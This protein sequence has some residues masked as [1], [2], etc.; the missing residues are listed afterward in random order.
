[1]KKAFIHTFGCQM[2]EYDSQRMAHLLTKGGYKLVQGVE[3]ANL[4]LLNSCS[5]RNAPENKIYSFLGR[6][7]NLKKKNKNLIIGVGGC[8]A[9]QEGANILKREPIVDLVF[10]TDNY[11]S[12]LEMLAEVEQG[13]R[14]L[15]TQW[16]PREKKIQN[17]VPFE[18]INKPYIQGCKAYL[19]ITK[20]CDNFCSFCV[21]PFTRGREVSRSVDNILLEADNLVKQGIKEI[22]LLGQNVNSYKAGDVDFYHLLKSLSEIEGLRRIRFTSPHPKD[23]NNKLTDLMASQPKICNQLHLPYQSGSNSILHLMR[24]GHTIEEYLKKIRYLKKII[25][26]I[27]L[28]TDLIVGFPSESEE[29]FQ[30]TL[31]VLKTI[32]FNQVYAFKYSS[33]PQT[34]A[35]KM[36]D[37]VLQK[38]KEE[39][40]AKVLNLFETIRS[41]KFE[42]LVGLEKKVLIEGVHPKKMDFFIGRSEENISISVKKEISSNIKVGDFIRVKIQGKKTHSLWGTT[43][44]E[45]KNEN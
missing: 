12:L 2:N 22:I 38:T 31:A 25:P 34:R 27:S 23:W 19:S 35:S 45:N 14:V 39:R 33:R 44:S 42:M 41:R 15:K 5:V 24:R 30:K 40:L 36:K 37:D 21:V 16:M 1:M 13:Q 32:K 17:F 4:I 6:A 26:E 9:Q 8:V 7:K 3:D 10:G 28:S 11:N 43:L 29:D 18:D 20:G